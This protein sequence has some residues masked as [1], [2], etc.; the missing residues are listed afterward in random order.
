[1]LNKLGRLIFLGFCAVIIQAQVLYAEK[2][3]GLS[4]KQIVNKTN[5]VAY[6]SGENGKAVVSMVITDKLGRKRTR[7]FVMLR[8][9]I[10]DCCKEQKYYT[11]FRRPA[12]INKMGY[13]VWKYIDKDDDRWLYLPALD[14]VKRISAADKRTSFVGSDFYYEDVSGRN[15]NLDK[16]TLLKTTKSF[17]VLKNVPKNPKI[18]E[19]SYFTMWID[20]KTFIPIK[21]DFFDKQGNLNRVYQALEIK[22]IQGYPTVTKAT[23][24]N[25]QSGSK[26]LMKFKGIKYDIDMPDKIFSERAL[27]I[28]PIKYLRF[29]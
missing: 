4:V 24:E 1:M 26:T 3:A 11:Y 28:P 29:K 13:L 16:H 22:I 15:L 7:E 9:N 18:V 25:I 27:R 23:M 12:D 20:K 10:G 14:L 17:Y 6:Y 2:P 21:V 8:K 19:F 5:E